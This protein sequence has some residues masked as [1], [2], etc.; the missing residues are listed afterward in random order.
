[1]K[2]GQIYQ[3]VAGE[4]RFPNR[5]VVETA[6]GESCFVDNALPGQKVEF[7]VEKAKNGRFY[8]RLLRLWGLFIPECPLH[9]AAP[10]Q[11]VPGPLPSGQSA[12]GL[13]VGGHQIQP[14]PD[15]LPQQDGV[16]LR[17]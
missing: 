17:Q 11:G 9:P 1:M 7:R 6:E 13:Q 5:A 10:L 12:G 4:I 8:G 15:R 14:R 16:Q 3:G 2:K